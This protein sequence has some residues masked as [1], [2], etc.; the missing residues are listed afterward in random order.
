MCGI[1][2]YLTQ[3]VPVTDSSTIRRMCDQLVHRGPD[4]EGY[5]CHGPVALGHR[6]LS[7][8]DLEGGAQ[9]LGN[10]DGSIQVVFNGE[11]Y[12]FPELHQ[13]LEQNGHKFRTRSDT[14]VLVHLY[15]EEGERIP[16]FLN[17]MFAFAIWDA[18]QESVFLARDRFG[19]KPLYYSFGAGGFRFCF[20]SEMKALVALPRF[21]GQINP[22][23]LKD[24]LA[25]SY[26]PDPD[27][28]F[29]DVFRLPP[30][31][32]LTVHKEGHQLRRYWTPSFRITS[33]TTLQDRVEETRALSSDAVQM[34]MVSDVPIGGF[35]SGGVD[36]SAVVAY[37][38]LNAPERVKTFS[39]GFTSEAFN[40]VEFARVVAGRYQ[41]DHYERTVTPDIL[42]MLDTLVAQYDE[43]FGDS[44]AIPTLYLSRMTREHVTVALSGDGGDE[45]F[46]GYRRYRFGV[47]EERM[48]SIFPEWFRHTAIG[49]LA[50]VYPKLDFLPRMFRAQATLRCISQELGDAYYT[51]M[52]TFRDTALDSVLAPE[53]ARQ[54]RDYS[55]RANFRKRFE[56]VQ[57]LPPLMQMQA[58]DFE[59]YLPGD[60][61]VK[62]D[63]AAM[64]YSL[65]SRAPWLDHR[66]VELACG[67][68]QNFKLRH[69]VGKYVFKQA[70]KRLLPEPILTR[71]KMGFA[72]PLSEWFRSS[73]KPVFESAVLRD[74]MEAYLN[75]QEVRRLWAQH[76]SGLRS[77][78]SELWNLLM[79]SLWVAR[80]QDG[81]C[82]AS[83]A[84]AS[85]GRTRP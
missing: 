55:P 12:N 21:P 5:F 10:E 47:A 1:A 3:G 35:L 59:T 64:A 38:A 16:E 70:L 75:L 28:I 7:I 50:E 51:S 52:T 18:R 22:R 29:R 63:R 65:E 84:T 2:G 4:G 6:R 25:F 41:T 57:H 68:P 30:A 62:V 58:V 53:M 39:I 33:G 23:A 34:R 80:Y 72:V 40:E 48:R 17:G 31:H 66:L 74:E 44:S 76:Q 42:E 37:M 15:E 83:L 24:F 46:G 36:S 14:E 82:V 85:S 67:M 9:P 43:P 19:E 20:A 45:V 61:L 71:S 27:T 56:A 73:L 81:A 60:I 13:R 49:G 11:I 78:G 69:G 26:I 32:S 54:L 77:R 8:I 79:L